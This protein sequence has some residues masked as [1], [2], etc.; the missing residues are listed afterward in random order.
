MNNKPIGH[1]LEY[2]IADLEYKVPFYDFKKPY[3]EF[4]HPG[5]VDYLERT[6]FFETHWL[7]YI[8]STDGNGFNW[9]NADRNK[10]VIYER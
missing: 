7:I 1:Y 10:V 2:V 6:D 9:I 8:K 4:Y 3:R 5:V